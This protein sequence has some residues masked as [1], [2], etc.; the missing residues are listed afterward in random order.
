[1]TGLRGLLLDVYCIVDSQIPNSIL[2][3][4]LRFAYSDI[5]RLHPV[6]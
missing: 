3:S 4:Q 6:R 2:L 5:C 1:M